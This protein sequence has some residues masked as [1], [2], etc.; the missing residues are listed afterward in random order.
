MEY[1]NAVYTQAGGIDCE[2]NHPELGWVPTTLRDDDQRELFAEVA[3][4]DVA[5]FVAQSITGDQVNEERDRRMTGILSFAGTTFDCD[6]K[7]LA[8]ITGAATLA[9]FAMGAGA[10]AGFMRWHGGDVDFAWI[11]ASNNV[12]PMDAQTCMSFGKAAAAWQS[13]HIFAGKAIKK[14][15]PIPQDYASDKYWP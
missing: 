1:R 8:R 7:S 10:P 15:D 13:A 5:A 2:I 9:G 11:D 4:G 12:V 6:E 3:G 14:L